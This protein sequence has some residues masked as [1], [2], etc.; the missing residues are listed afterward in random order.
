MANVYFPNS[1]IPELENSTAEGPGPVL[2]SSL[3]PL[4]G[5]PLPVGLLKAKLRPFCLP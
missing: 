3:S 2:K 4:T 1:V 5:P